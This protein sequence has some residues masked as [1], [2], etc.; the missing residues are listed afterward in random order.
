MNRTVDPWANPGELLNAL[1]EGLIVAEISDASSART[2]PEPR[3]ES[4][5]TLGIKSVRAS[6]ASVSARRRISK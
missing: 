2:Q 4:R 1:L 3:L 6:S 5:R